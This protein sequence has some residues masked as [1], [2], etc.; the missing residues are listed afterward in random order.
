MRESLL[1]TARVYQVTDQCDA[2]I[3]L[4]ARGKMA[5]AEDNFDELVHILEQ[6][7][8]LLESL[9]GQAVTDAERAVIA[10]TARKILAEDERIAGSLKAKMSEALIQ[11]KEIKQRRRLMR[12]YSPMAGYD[13]RACVDRTA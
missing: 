13:G 1:S 8:R 6:R 7:Q 10:E 3:T 2:L 9:K 11:L 5:L 12:T 4:A